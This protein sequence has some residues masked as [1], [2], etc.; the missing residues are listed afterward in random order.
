MLDFTGS[1]EGSLHLHLSHLQL[2]HKRGQ[3]CFISSFVLADPFF[4]F[5]GSLFEK[6]VFVPLQFQAP[7][8]MLCTLSTGKY[9]RRGGC[10]R[11]PQQRFP[12]G[13]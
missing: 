11:A 12:S 7:F 2:L 10:E 6:Q 3:L 4:S 5:I 9:N 13:C 8:A 1:L